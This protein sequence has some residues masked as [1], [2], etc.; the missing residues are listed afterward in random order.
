MK[1]WLQQN[2]YVTTQDTHISTITR[3]LKQNFVAIFSKYVATESKKKAR[4]YVAKENFKPRQK[5]ENKDDN[6]VAR[7]AT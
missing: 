6:Y 5:L 7:L 4:K 3:Q 1:H 2:F